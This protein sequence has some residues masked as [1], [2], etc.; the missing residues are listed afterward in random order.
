RGFN[1][2]LRDLIA[3]LKRLGVRPRRFAQACYARGYEGTAPARTL[4][5]RA[6]SSKD[7]ECARL[8]ARYEKRL[9]LQRL[10][11]VEGRPLLAAQ[12]VPATGLQPP[13]ARVRSVFLAGFTDFTPAQF[14]VLAILAQHV[15]E[16][17]ASLPDEE[18]DLRA[19]LFAPSRATAALL[20]PLS[21]HV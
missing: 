16:I 6:I 11:D 5:G 19:E 15:G 12:L 1:A 21:P 14:G 17:W 8:Y 2:G 20:S 13:F 7:R 3:E 10:V 9:E 18:G 4:R